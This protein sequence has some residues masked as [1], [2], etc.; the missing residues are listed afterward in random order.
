[1]LTGRTQYTRSGSSAHFAR[2]SLTADSNVPQ[3]AARCVDQFALAGDGYGTHPRW[4]SIFSTK[5]A[6]GTAPTTVS[7]CWPSLK[8]SMLG[9]ERTAKRIAVS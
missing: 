2:R 7:T 6:F 4:R 3:C 5:C 1:M 8:K 9:I